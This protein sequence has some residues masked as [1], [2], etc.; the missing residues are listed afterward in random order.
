MNTIYKS[1]SNKKTTTNY[2]FKNKTFV[3]EI[4]LIMSI[5]ANTCLSFLIKNRKKKPNGLY[6]KQQQLRKINVE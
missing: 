5:M 4:I 3:I 1:T 2:G 6:E